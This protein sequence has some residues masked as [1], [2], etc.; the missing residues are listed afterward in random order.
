MEGLRKVFSCIG[1]NS[2]DSKEDAPKS[3]HKMESV[4]DSIKATVYGNCIG[5]AIGLLSEFMSKTDAEKSYGKHAG[6]IAYKMKVDDGHRSRWEVGDWTDDSD[7]MILIMKS[8]L[9]NEGEVNVVDYS[10]KLKDWQQHGFEELGDK[11]GMGIGTTT[12][13][14][15][16]HEKFLEDPHAAAEQVWER[17]NRRVAP[18]GGVMRTS[19]AGVYR[20]N[21]IEA[22]IRNTL[23]F[24]KVTH[25]DPRCQASCVAV[26]TAIAQMLQRKHV[27]ET[28]RHD[29]D[30]IM[31]ESFEHAKKYLVNAEGSQDEEFVTEFR[32]HMF[33]ESISD[34]QLGEEQKIGY[35]LK[36]M[37]AGFWAF[38]Q[39]NFRTA[40]EA[41]LFEGGDADTNGAVAGALLGC[42]LGLKA[43]P[44]SWLNQLLHKTWLDGILERFI[45][46][47]ETKQT[48]NTATTEE[49][50]AQEEQAAEQDQKPEPDQEQEQ[51]PEQEQEQNEE[52]QK[53]ESQQEQEQN[54]KQIDNSTAIDQSEVEITTAAD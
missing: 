5:D 35:T 44:K 29:A 21:D 31:E 40:L 37:G 50:N 20:F 33:A 28:G 34:L 18:N 47:T 1:K 27:D 24:C 49:Q 9:D 17:S 3:L 7:Q 39:T 4:T 38:R 41:V 8:L 2:E 25:A 16:T 13:Q 51:K 54:G 6:K 10:K 23:S 42:K 53:E 19:V 26:T 48:E 11:G 46:L 52:P 43:F 22:V 12:V 45:E 15:L 32:R 36:T 14:V 30:K